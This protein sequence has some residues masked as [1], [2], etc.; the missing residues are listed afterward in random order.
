M[1]VFGLPQSKQRRPVSQ[2]RD[3]HAD[4]PK[5]TEVG[6][7]LLVRPNRDQPLGI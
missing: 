4:G 6:A 5:L 2:N 7:I 1:R 3:L